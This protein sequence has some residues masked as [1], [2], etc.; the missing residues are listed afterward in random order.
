M[1]GILDE[2]VFSKKKRIKIQKEK[3]SLKGIMAQC[4]K[5]SHKNSSFVKAIAF[6]NQVSIIAE[7]KKRSPSAGVLVKNYFPEKIA[8]LY[9]KA[10]ASA[11][12]VLTEQDYFDGRAEDIVKARK[13]SSLPILRK[14]FIFDPYQIYESKILGASAIL[15]IIAILKK[16]NYAEL[17]KLT[18]ELG[19]SA[20]VEVHTEK[21]LEM[22]LTEKPDII[23]INNRNLKTL[24]VNIE[25]SFKLEEQ[26]PK[27]I[28]I[29]AE[30][31]IKSPET[32]RQL[33]SAGISAALIGESILKSHDPQKILKSF[34]EAGR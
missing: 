34:V 15:L 11:L 3:V 14:D 4:G 21:E 12:S 18:K 28:P 6:P 20:L 1:S 23:G 25:T 31:G 29:V 26:V 8:K 33:K 24:M 27:G 19:M 17:L 5:L 9:E 22:A 7:M 10:G 13:E 32:I 16:Q 2:I 30:S